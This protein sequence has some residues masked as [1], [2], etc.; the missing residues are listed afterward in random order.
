MDCR[1]YNH[2]LKAYFHRWA[3]NCGYIAKTRIL[4]DDRTKHNTFV[5]SLSD[6]Q[7]EMWTKRDMLDVV[8]VSGKPRALIDHPMPIDPP[9]WLCLSCPGVR[10]SIGHYIDSRYQPYSCWCGQPLKML[11][12]EWLVCECCEDC[13]KRWSERKAGCALWLLL[14][15]VVLPRELVM[16]IAWLLADVL[17]DYA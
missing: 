15:P 10:M 6:R 5:D 8:H 16:I 2:R 7:L 17:P 1:P 3:Q 4:G 11:D 14:G 13:K 12:G 9:R